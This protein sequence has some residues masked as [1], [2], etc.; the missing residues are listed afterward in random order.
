MVNAARLVGPSL[1]GM[2]IAVSSEGWCFLINGLSYIAVLASLLM[3]RLDTPV[4]ERSTTSAPEARASVAVSSLQ[5]SATT[6]IR[7]GG[8]FCR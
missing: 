5:L 4:V 2:L 6:T 8:V 7:S 3:M 1:A